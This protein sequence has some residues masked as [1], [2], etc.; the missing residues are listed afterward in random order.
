MLFKLCPLG[1][2]FEVVGAVGVVGVVG[3]VLIYF[4]LQARMLRLPLP[5]LS[6]SVVG[7]IG[8]ESSAAASDPAPGEGMRM[9]RNDCDCEL[10][11]PGLL[12]EKANPCMKFTL[13][14]V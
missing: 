1:K 6:R 8:E 2:P 13:C 5:A 4:L 9:G 14:K 3:D 7:E 11:P 12:F 10:P